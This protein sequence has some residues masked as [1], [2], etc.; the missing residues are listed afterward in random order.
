MTDRREQ[1]GRLTMADPLAYWLGCFAAMPIS[2]PEVPYYLLAFGILGI[3]GVTLIVRMSRPLNDIAVYAAAVGILMCAIAIVSSL[4]SPYQE[5]LGPA[6]IGTT[7]FFYLFFICGLAVANPERFF[8]G[9]VDALALQAALVVIASIF[10]LP[11]SAGALVFSVP[12]FRLWGAGLFPDWPNFYAAMLCM[13]FIAAIALQGRWSIGLLCLAAAFLTTSRTVFLAVGI[14]LTWYV[15]FRHRR[16]VAIRMVVVLGAIIGVFGLGIV[17]M[18]GALDSELSS[19]L[20]LISDRMEI[21]WS[22]IDLLLK[23]PLTGVGGVLLDYRVGNLGAASFHNSYLE[24]AVRTGLIGLAI[25]LPLIFLPLFLLRWSDGLIPLVVFV[26]AGSLFQ[27]LLRHPHI[28]IVFSIMIAWAGLRYR[29]RLS[30]RVHQSA[31]IE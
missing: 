27:N 20:L 4:L 19:R 3:C 14:L 18:S 5:L 7:S 22:S 13:A 30:A 15:V 31:I 2:Y 25:Y 12:E 24:V 29:E 10:Y 21:F 17:L 23:T 28:A 8:R 9:F 26:L 6:R 16:H 11:W 1:A